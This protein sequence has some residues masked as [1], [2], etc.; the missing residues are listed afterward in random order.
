[1]TVEFYGSTNGTLPTRTTYNNL[2][3]TDGATRTQANVNVTVNGIFHLDAGILSNTSFNKTL[4]L[5]KNWVNDVGS[6]GYVPGQG[7]AVFASDS[8]Q[9]IDGIS[10]F[11]ILEFSGSGSKTLLDSL[12]V[13]YQLL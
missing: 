3:F 9:S 2:L 8:A 13:G 6:A 11:Y 10:N 12:S 7:K 5:K 1:G 4:T